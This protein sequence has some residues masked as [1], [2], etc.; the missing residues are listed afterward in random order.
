MVAG[1]EQ[2]EL[3]RLIAGL[4]SLPLSDRRYTVADSTGTIVATAVVPNIAPGV[5][6]SGSKNSI[7]TVALADYRKYRVRLK[8]IGF[9]APVFASPLWTSDAVAGKWGGGGGGVEGG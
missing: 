9:G 7:T 5:A 1:T 6:L 3:L 8:A 2:K 4:H